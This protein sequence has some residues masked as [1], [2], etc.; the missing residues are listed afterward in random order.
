MLVNTYFALKGCGLMMW[1]I[2]P[3]DI[4]ISCILKEITMYHK[5]VHC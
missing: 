2:F 5:V 3:I 1:N 4:D